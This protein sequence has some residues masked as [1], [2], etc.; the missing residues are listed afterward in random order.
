MGKEQLYPQVAVSTDILGPRGNDHDLDNF[1]PS[2]VGREVV[3]WRWT[4]HVREA[5]LKVVCL[6]GRV[7]PVE[8]K[9]GPVEELKLRLVNAALEPTPNLV[10]KYKGYEIL[11]HGSE[12]RD[13]K[14]IKTI[15]IANP[16]MVWVENNPPGRSGVDEA[17]YWVQ[18][19]RRADQD[20][21]FMFDPCHFIPDEHLHSEE[22]PKYWQKFMQIL[23]LELPWI[24]DVYGKK[25]PVG[26]H[27]PIGTYEK[28]S[29]PIEDS[30]LFPDEILREL[31]M[32]ARATHVRCVVL[33]NQ[34]EEM[35]GLRFL[36]GVKDKEATIVRTQATVHRLQETGVIYLP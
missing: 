22:F 23:A 32:V 21:G 17:L 9:K 7:G 36:T 26:L 29:L 18:K 35:R 27:F 1:Y 16:P 11:V 31:A 3:M 34:P 19:L 15:I 20:A 28:D 10:A 24:R 25:I 6:H 14:N 5:G 33:E 13:P 12:L 30:K 2:G 8:G 4:P